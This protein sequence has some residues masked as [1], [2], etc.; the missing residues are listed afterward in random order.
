MI[1]ALRGKCKL[2]AGV[3]TAGIFLTQQKDDQLMMH[4]RFALL[5]TL[6]LLPVLA[7]AQLAKLTVVV[8]GIEPSTGTVEVSVFNTAESFMQKPLLQQSRKVDGLAETTFK[9]AGVLEGQ[10]AV[11]VVHDENGNGVLDAGFLGFGGESFAYSN[12]AKSWLGRPSFEDASFTVSKD[13]VEILI[14]LE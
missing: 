9:F 5:A 8:S 13:D 10:Y 1:A 11:V 4:L 12:D 6:I 3:Q 14:G 2:Q 7:H